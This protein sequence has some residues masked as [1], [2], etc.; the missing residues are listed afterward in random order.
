VLNPVDVKPVLNK[1]LKRGGSFAEVFFENTA[2]TTVVFENKSLDQIVSGIDCGVGLRILEGTDTAYGYTN[3]LAQKSLLDLAGRVSDAGSSQVSDKDIN[4]KIQAPKITLPVT[5]DP[6]IVPAADKIAVCRSANDLAWKLD[7]RIIQVRIRYHD[8]VRAIQVIN[9]DGL[10]SESSKTL[11]A[12]SV[13]IT[14][15]DDHSVQTGFETLGGLCGFE[16]YDP[17][18]VEAA[19]RTAARRAVLNLTARPAPGGTMTV[20]LASEAGGTMIHEAVGHGLEADL[21]CEGLSVFGGRLGERVANPLITVIDDGTLGGLRGTSVCDDEGRAT[22]RNVLIE[23]GVLKS[24]M[25]DRFSAG[26]HGLAMTGNG[27]RESY[28]F[29]PIV[30]MTNTFVAPGK[31]DPAEIVASVDRG[32]FVKKMGGGQVNTVNGD[33]VFEVTEGYLIENGKIAEPV[34]GATLVGNGPEV[35]RII[36]RVGNDLGF[37]FGQC[38]KNG[39]GVPVTDAIP[40][41]RIPQ[42]LVGGKV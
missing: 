25:V 27:R 16:L 4:L 3:D 14:A 35:I 34:R 38:G 19:V 41:L 1:A 42:L 37:S 29:R 23:N 30:R 15:R 5:R 13:L 31:D 11:T 18:A 7:K 40:T 33:F 8:V 17:N 32:L 39:Q 22:A 12:F 10:F 24:Y 21:A 2:A 6:L 26:K 9:S 36:D 20:V 28:E